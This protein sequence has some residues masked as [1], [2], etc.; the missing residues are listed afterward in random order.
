MM[1]FL[2]EVE[3]ESICPAR[4]SCHHGLEVRGLGA[5]KRREQAEGKKKD[6]T[7]ADFFFSLSVSVTTALCPHVTHYV[8]STCLD[9][10]QHSTGTKAGTEQ[11]SA[12]SCFETDQVSISGNIRGWQANYAII[13][14][15]M[16]VI[17]PVLRNSR[18]VW[19]WDIC[20]LEVTLQRPGNLRSATMGS[21]R[22]VTHGI[23]ERGCPTSA[24]PA[25]PRLGRRNFTMNAEEK[26]TFCL[27]PL[28]TPSAPS[29]CLHTDIS[30]CVNK[31]K[32]TALV[33]SIVWHSDA[34]VLQSHCV[35]DSNEMASL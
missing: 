5:R 10:S 35:F 9:K 23:R 14:H 1:R 4:P 18:S 8:L 2:T 16:C 25:L 26:Y 31:K 20:C 34:L 24:S 7:T 32:K 30:V 12:K 19:V 29:P 11:M 6:K 17:P 33:L 15:R 13:F 21:R 22:S 3:G 28:S 27:P